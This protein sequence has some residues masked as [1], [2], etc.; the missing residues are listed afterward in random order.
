M[1]PTCDTCEAVDETVEWCGSCGSC[2]AHC[3]NYVGCPS[4]PFRTHSH[5]DERLT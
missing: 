1:T 5:A 3:Q 2:L 4:R